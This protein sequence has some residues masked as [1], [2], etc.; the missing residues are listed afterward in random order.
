MS[1]AAPGWYPVEGGQRYW[2]GQQ[3]TEHF[4][5]EQQQPATKTKEPKV[6]ARHP[7]AD[8]PDTIWSAVGK[9]LSHVGAGRYRLTPL[10]LHFERGALRTNA[11][12][13]PIHEVYDVDAHQTMQQKA[14]GVGTITLIVHRSAGNETVKLEDVADFRAGVHAINEAAHRRREEMQTRST[15][16]TINYSGTP[17]GAHAIPV[18]ATAG[19]GAAPASADDVFALLERLGKLR[20]AGIVTDEEFVT[21]KAELLS[22]L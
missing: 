14:R 15:T 4:H 18:A 8:D 20:E 16:S 21:K 5:P 3:W 19:A 6:E 1:S 7:Q 17:I 22:R 12:Q 9:P 13:I 2:D 10:F 11:Q